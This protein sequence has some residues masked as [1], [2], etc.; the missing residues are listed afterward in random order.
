MKTKTTPS[1]QTPDALL[2]D[3]HTLVSEAEKMIGESIS[4]PAAD[5]VESLRARFAV[6]QES[7]GEMYATAKHKTVA[8]AQTAAH[9]TDHA[10]RANPY[11]SLAI[12]AGVGLIIGVLL[13]RRSN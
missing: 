8:A 1:A 12:A 7:L 10:I 11:Q 5:A 3:L 9:T 4:E 6:A 13:G 2:A